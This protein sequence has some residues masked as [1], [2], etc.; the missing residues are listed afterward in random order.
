MALPVK[1]VVAQVATN[2]IQEII[3]KIFGVKVDNSEANR[4]RDA[5]VNAG[6]AKNWFEWVR[7]NAGYRQYLSDEDINYLEAA[8]LPKVSANPYYGGLDTSYSSKYGLWSG[9]TVP[10]VGLAQD[11]DRYIEQKLQIQEQDLP[12]IGAKY[13]TDKNGNIVINAG[14]AEQRQIPVNP[15][16]DK[17]SFLE[18]FLAL[19]PFWNT[20]REEHP[21]MTIIP[22]DSGGQTPVIIQQPAPVPAI[23]T[24]I[25]LFGALIFSGIFIFKKK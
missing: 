8:L 3:N 20:Q 7:G 16:S 5:G 2:K 17:S 19:L 24:K 12:E 11:V 18:S 6:H 1:A 9:N 25:L 14:A 22:A 15:G 13:Y 10:A 23:D 4:Q 21:R